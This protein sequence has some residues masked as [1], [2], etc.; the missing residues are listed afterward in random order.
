MNAAI[1]FDA[2]LLCHDVDT[3]AHNVVIIRCQFDPNDL[4]RVEPKLLHDRFRG[5][6]PLVEDD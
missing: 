3:P 5:V 6:T 4:G 1:F 2:N